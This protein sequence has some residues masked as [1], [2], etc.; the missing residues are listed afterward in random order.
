MNS[1]TSLLESRVYRDKKSS[2][3]LVPA[4][5]VSVVVFGCASVGSGPAPL[6][7]FR[8]GLV[9]SSEELGNVFRP[10]ERKTESPKEA[11]RSILTSVHGRLPGCPGFGV[12]Q[13]TSRLEV[14]FLL[15]E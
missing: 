7:I 1:R 14:F 13:V 8:F 10:E 11:Q 9:D 3:H 2:L 4:P 5:T 12:Q 15:E 6:K